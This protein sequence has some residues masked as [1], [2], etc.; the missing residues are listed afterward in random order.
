MTAPT[1]NPAT[2]TPPATD[3]PAGDSKAS[4]SAPTTTGGGDGTTGATEQVGTE[5]DEWANFDAARAKQTITHQRKVEADLK[6]ELAEQRK[7]VEEFER[8]QM[9]EAERVKA[10]LEAAQR[11]R[12]EAVKATAALRQQ[13]AFDTAAVAAGILP[14]ALT[15]A[16]TIAAEVATSDEAGNMTVDDALF[17]R[18][19]AEHGYLFTAKQAAPPQVTFGA[20]AS[21]GPGGNTTT[22]TPEQVAFAQKAGIEPED[23]AKNLPQ[24]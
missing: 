22:L 1:T 6:R 4:P 9:T 16:R 7:K 15:A 12:D 23:F 20:A 17:D 19:K 3:P 2:A 14:N 18:L 24:R 5:A 10:D 13:Q 11:E 21:Q 8:A